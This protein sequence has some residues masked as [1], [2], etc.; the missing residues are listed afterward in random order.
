MSRSLKV[1]GVAILGTG[2]GFA[3][4][5]KFAE[6]RL[7]ARFEE[8]LEAETAGMR[9][10]YTN[11]KQKYDT[12]EEAA[13]ALIPEE[14]VSEDP[15]A[16]HHKVQYNKIVKEKYGDPLDEFAEGCEIDEVVKKN[17]FEEQLPGTPRIITQDEFMANETGY[18]QASLTYYANGGVLTD[19]R[20]EVIENVDDVAGTMFVVNFGEGSSDSNVV[21]VRNDKIFMDFEIVRSERS[22]N[23]DVLGLEDTG[24]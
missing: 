21:H 5:Y 19:Q 24:G 3:I 16:R 1:T 14:E 13:A 17:V 6:N 2:I 20:D 15:R 18:E 4:G 11:V 8:R 7:G 12:P 23:E 22:Y 9:E 10:Y